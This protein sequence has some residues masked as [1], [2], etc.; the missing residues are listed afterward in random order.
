VIKSALL[1]STLY[2]TSLKNDEIT[3]SFIS[4]Q[5]AKRHQP[6]IDALS[7]QTGWRL[8]IN[9]QPN[10]GAILEVARA[11]IAK[12]GFGISKGP[13]IHPEKAEVSL[14]LSGLIEAEK[15]LELAEDFARETGF[16]LLVSCSSPKAEPV[17]RENP[18]GIVEIPVDR[19]RLTGYQQ[20]LSLDPAKLE[21]ALERARL[22]GITPPIQVRRAK[23]DY[24]LLDGLYRLRA[25]QALGLERIPALVE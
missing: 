4:P 14:V 17:S 21:K 1:G 7:E 18:A 5:V 2:R 10:Q 16:R 12:A 23:E 11:L 20:A 8:G 22:M 6:T 25:A 19:I 3:L 15:L 13:G 9:P 24:V